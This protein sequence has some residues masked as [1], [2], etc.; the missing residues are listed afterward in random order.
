MHVTFWVHGLLKIVY[1]QSNFT[2]INFS[3]I[4]VYKWFTYLVSEALSSRLIFCY[5]QI[6]WNS[7]SCHAHSNKHAIPTVGLVLI[8]RI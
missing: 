3:I 7:T 6:K 1:T 4:V 5:M 8:A 2:D